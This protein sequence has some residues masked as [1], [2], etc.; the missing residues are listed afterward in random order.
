MLAPA[1]ENI[2]VVGFVDTGTVEDTEDSLSADRVRLTVG[3]GLRLTIPAMGPAPLAFDFGI[4]I[5]SEDF[6]DER[7]FS[8]YVGISR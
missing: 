4:P 6:D 7:I 3:A 5:L 1:E 2:R 8:F